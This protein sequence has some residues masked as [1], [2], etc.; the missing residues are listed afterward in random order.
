MRTPLM[1]AAALAIGIAATTAAAAIQAPS[2]IDS[3]LHFDYDLASS[4]SGRPEVRGYIYND[5]MRAA[6]NV[7]L[8][9]ETVDGAG[10]V[11]GRSYGYVVGV[12]PPFNR[13]PFVVPVK[14][15]GGSYRLTVTNYEWR[16]GAA[17]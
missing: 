10:Q 17:M 11:V 12:V 15:A 9:V 2:G 14:T 13:A 3:R 1:L 7:R 4:R 5:Y 8:L 16:D 6:S